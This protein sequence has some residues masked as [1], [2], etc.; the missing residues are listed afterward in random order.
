LRETDRERVGV[1]GLYDPL[2]PGLAAA[3]AR[4][5]RLVAEYNATSDAETELR[6]LLLRTLLDRVGEDCWIEPPFFCDY[7][8]N[9][10]VGERFYAN[11]GCVFLDCAHIEIGNRVLLGPGVQ[12]L[13]ATHPLDAALRAEGLE[14]A[15]PITI[16]DDVWLGGGVIVLP[17][18]TIGERAVVG[19]GSVVTHDVP[20]ETVVVG[21]P[22]RVLRT[23]VA[24]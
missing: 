3:R 1:N 18:I 6:S 17:G 24:A 9:V 5:K 12:L 21:N 22:A 19:A 4:A 14:Y 15:L 8:T 11:T 23:A 13:A 16:G 10:V 7:G 20:A 2:D